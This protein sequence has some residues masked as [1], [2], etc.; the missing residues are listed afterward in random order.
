MRRTGSVAGP[1]GST[2]VF[3]VGETIPSRSLDHD[4]AAILTGNGSSSYVYVGESINPDTGSLGSHTGVKVTGA[5]NS[6]HGNYVCTSGALSGTVCDIKVTQTNV[7]VVYDPPVAGVGRVVG[8]VG[9]EH[10][11]RAVAGTGDSGGPV[12][13]IN[14]LLDGV[15]ARGVISSIAFGSNGEYVKS[16]SGWTQ[17]GQRPCSRK[18][19]FG[20]VL[21]IMRDIGVRINT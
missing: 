5:A 18:L 12:F 3:T 8:M 14:V 10:P 17:Q 13:A 2:L 6:Y 7:T 4:G 1:N 21:D 9:A 16:C 19:Y 20:P 11:D 15:T